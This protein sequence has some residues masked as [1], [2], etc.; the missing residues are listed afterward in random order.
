MFVCE[1]L[2]GFGLWTSLLNPVFSCRF[3]LQ[4]SS[5]LYTIPLFLSV[6]YSVKDHVKMSLLFQPVDEDVMCY[7]FE[8]DNKFR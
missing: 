7:S 5:Y 2:I 4:T 3:K 8:M 1:M 6:K